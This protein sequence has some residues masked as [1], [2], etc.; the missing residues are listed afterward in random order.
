MNQKI[1]IGLGALI[2]VLLVWNV[3]LNTRTETVSN[4]DLKE[5]LMNDS[6]ERKQDNE[7][8]ME[9]VSQ[10]QTEIK[11]IDNEIIEDSIFVHSASL[12]T[13]VNWLR[14]YLNAK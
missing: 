8:I 7:R 4:D 12:D 10:L 9:S 14:N 13:K 6:Q 1:I 2:V 5:Y 11:Q 3:I